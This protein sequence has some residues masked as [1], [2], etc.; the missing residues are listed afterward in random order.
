M[1][2]DGSRRGS[3]D[4]QGAGFG[5]LLRR[6]RREA[7]LSQE[8]LAELAGLSVDAIAALERGRRRAPRA[9]TLR[10]LTDALRLGDP[11][12]A[13]LTAAARRE[14]DSARGP[15]RQPPAPI[16]EL[17]GRTTELN[18]TSR[19]L[20]QGITRLLTLTGPGGVGKTRLT[21]A[22]ASKV[23]DSFPDGVCWVP[24]AAVTDSAAVAPTLAT[25]IGMHL[26]ES[27]RLVE[28]IAEQIGRST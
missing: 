23:S 28:E 12:R 15:V 26:L 27:T 21:L 5:G 19:L 3:D 8:K 10:L 13:L 14:A 4:V 6:H 16:S 2:S 22:L 11:D 7:G 20:G 9:H 24:L 1:P 25:S 17:I 18:A